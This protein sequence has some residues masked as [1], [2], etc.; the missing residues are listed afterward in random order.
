M[1]RVLIYGGRSYSNFTHLV[2]FMDKQLP[3]A[4]VVISGHAGK[5]IQQKGKWVTIGADRLG[6]LWAKS[7][8]IQ[9]IQFIPK[10]N[11]LNAPGAIIKTSHRT[12]FQYNA[13]AGPQRNAR[14]IAEG[15]PDYA[16]EF[17]GDLG[18]LDMRKQLQ[19]AGIEIREAY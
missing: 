4:T 16:V 17:P 10:W 9:V 14:M 11:D 7:L 13:A 6:E 19:A 18:T 3:R 8:G 12:G 15:K 5:R 2:E 1:T